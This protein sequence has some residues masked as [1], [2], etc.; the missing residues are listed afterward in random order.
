[1]VPCIMNQCFNKKVQ[2]DATVCRHLF[3][4]KSLYTF[5]ASAP[6]IRSTKNCNRYLWYNLYQR[7]RLQF[8]VLLIM[9]AVTPETCRVTLQ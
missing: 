1:M 5:R 9:G 8:L 2:L 6:I 7:Q 3:T 4:A